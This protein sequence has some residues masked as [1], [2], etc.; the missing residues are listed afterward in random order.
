MVRIS[1][2]PS[3]GSDDRCEPSENRCGP[4][5][6]FHL[7]CLPGHS[8]TTSGPNVMLKLRPNHPLTR[9]HVRRLGRCF[10]TVGW[11]TDL[12]PANRQTS[13]GGSAEA[14]EDAIANSW[15]R[16]CPCAPPEVRTPDQG[17]PARRQNGEAKKRSLR[18]LDGTTVRHEPCDRE[19]RLTAETQ[20]RGA[21]RQNAIVR[22]PLRPFPKT[23]LRGVIRR[24]QNASISKKSSNRKARR[25]REPFWDPQLDVPPSEIIL[26]PQDFEG[27][28]SS[29]VSRT[30][31][32]SLQSYCNFP[33]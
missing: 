13:D 23:G 19:N 28:V 20:V 6:E 18:G 9:T 1:L 8:F 11:V 25:I 4:P 21:T 17:I 10:K 22:S 29:S 24:E 2:R 27:H 16:D 3:Q 31:E 33:H 7:A 26:P 32:L 30:L 5:P 14:N 12:T 15:A